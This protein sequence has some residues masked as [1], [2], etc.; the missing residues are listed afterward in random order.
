MKSI[1]VMALLAL[2]GA[3]IFSTWV[4]VRANG[5]PELDQPMPQSVKAFKYLYASDAE[6][7]AKDV[8]RK[9]MCDINLESGRLIVINSETVISS[10]N[11]YTLAARPGI[12]PVNFYAHV[13][14][15]AMNQSALAMSEV[16]FSNEPP[17]RWQ[18]AVSKDKFVFKDENSGIMLYDQHT[19]L[20]SFL[21]IEVA[22]KIAEYDRYP[23]G[24][25]SYLDR[26][27]AARC[28]GADKPAAKG[29]IF[30]VFTSNEKRAYPL[31]DQW[32]D[33][34]YPSY[35]GIGADGNPVTLVTTYLYL[36]EDL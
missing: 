7:E 2:V 6:L 4:I 33:K 5:T 22:A 21:S 3:A 23:G 18:R 9:K 10:A 28:M 27:E 31:R 35:F 1:R 14:S 32:R 20:G 24:G 25:R 8:Y 29:V 26:F 17:V 11:A 12:Y 15:D 36:E 13:P 30:P 34:P 16:R 19:A